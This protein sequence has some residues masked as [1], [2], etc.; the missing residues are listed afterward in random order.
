M[1]EQDDYARHVRERQEFAK[2]ADSNAAR[3][4]LSTDPSY[5]YR[6]R[7]YSGEWGPW[8]PAL[9]RAFLFWSEQPDVEV[10]TVRRPT[11]CR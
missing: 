4:G 5:E 8:V 10:R 3:Q 9:Q 1:N 2:Q 7:S 6:K 11:S